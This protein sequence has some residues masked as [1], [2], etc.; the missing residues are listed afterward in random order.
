MEYCKC[1]IC[2]CYREERSYSTICE[3]CEN[4]GNE[5]F[6]DQFSRASK[7]MEN[8]VAELESDVK[9]LKREL[10]LK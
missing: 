9:R 2:D 6:A 1:S 7:T 5:G 4:H 10:G 8:R 3:H